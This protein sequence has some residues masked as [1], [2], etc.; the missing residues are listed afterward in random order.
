[1]ITTTG[2]T[3]PRNIVVPRKEWDEA[4][5]E[6]NQAVQTSQGLDEY[7]E[8]H[9]TAAR[10]KA[11]LMKFCVATFNWK[12]LYLRMKEAIRSNNDK[13]SRMFAKRERWDFALMVNTPS[14]QSMLQRKN[15]SSEE[16]TNDSRFSTSCN[17]I[18]LYQ[19]SDRFSHHKEFSG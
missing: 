7:R 9:K 8:R 12:H 3:L 18:D 2:D 11:A 6:Y 1:M 10:N 13:I 14:Y 19:P 17:V 16:I 5:A 15:W 4:I